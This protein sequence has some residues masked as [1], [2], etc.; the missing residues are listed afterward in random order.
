[1]IKILRLIVIF[2]YVL[3]MLCVIILGLEL[4]GADLDILLIRTSS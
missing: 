3:V 1:M 2:D 4:A